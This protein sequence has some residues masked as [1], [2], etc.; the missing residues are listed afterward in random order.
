MQAV[1]T[2]VLQCFAGT[3]NPRT[4]KY[5]YACDNDLSHRQ[6]IVLDTPVTNYRVVIP[7]DVYDETREKRK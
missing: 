1:E 2:T 3:K 4:T 6:L 7:A 5:R